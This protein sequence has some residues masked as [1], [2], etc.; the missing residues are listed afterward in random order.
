MSLEDH[1]V[2]KFEKDD[3]DIYFDCPCGE[4]SCKPA[5]GD[6]FHWHHEVCPECGTPKEKFKKVIKRYVPKQKVIIESHW[7]VRE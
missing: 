3:F 5:F 6:V 7:E 1:I 4:F 2:G